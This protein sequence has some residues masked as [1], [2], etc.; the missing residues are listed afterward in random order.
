M[1]KKKVVEKV[2]ETPVVFFL[3]IVEKE[4]QAPYESST[5][6]EI[7]ESPEDYHSSYSKILEGQTAEPRFTNDILKPI[8]E[9]MKKTAHSE[10][11]S[12]FW[13]CHTFVGPQFSLPLSYDTYKNF[14]ICKGNFCSPECALAY[15]YADYTISDSTRWNKHVLLNTLY[16]PLYTESVSPAPPRSLL[17]MFGGP[18]DIKQYRSYFAVND[19]I[20]ESF[21]PIKLVFPVMAIQGPLRDI[22]KVVSLSS[23]VI[24]KASESLRLKRSK[25][26]NLNI[27]TLDLCIK[28]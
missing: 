28:N 22:K 21:P 6:A 12:C 2:K 18:L 1:A 10:H 9:S 13:C 15:L 7:Q 23:E 26:V 8:L 14:Y 20:H 19:L 17:R 5:Y 24:E 27:P 4:E 16:A 25:P 3:R 11:D